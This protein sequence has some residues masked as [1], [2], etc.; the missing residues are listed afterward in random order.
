MHIFF[1]P[2]AAWL[3]YIYFVNFY[4]FLK[5]GTLELDTDLTVHTQMWEKCS[6][7]V[8][9][10]PQVWSIYR[11]TAC[12]LND[13]ENWD[14]GNI[15]NLSGQAYFMVVIQKN[16]RHAKQ[17]I[18]KVNSTFY[19]EVKVLHMLYF[20]IQLFLGSKLALLFLLSEEWLWLS[21]VMP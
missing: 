6:L 13:S 10:L 11:Y 2:S 8:H 5:V 12:L 7:A 19:G 3:N 17:W 21:W 4:C 14:L 20:K 15:L 18:K 16:I 1:C 9:G